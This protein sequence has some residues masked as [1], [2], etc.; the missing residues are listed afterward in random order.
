MSVDEDFFHEMGRMESVQDVSNCDVAWFVVAYKDAPD[1]SFALERKQVFLTTLEHSVD[2]LV[3]ARPVTKAR[4]EQKILS[5]L[6]A[7]NS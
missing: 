1:G 2:G 3:A 7:I 6:G 5:K 4:F